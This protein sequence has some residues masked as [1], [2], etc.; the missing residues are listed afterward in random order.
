MSM[1]DFIL[2]VVY[3]LVPIACNF[4][5]KSHLPTNCVICATHIRGMEIHLKE[6]YFESKYH[7][8]IVKSLKWQ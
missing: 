4:A 3:L 6:R 2:L 5:K 1:K 7:N 8:V